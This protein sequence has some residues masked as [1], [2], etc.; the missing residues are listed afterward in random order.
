M[1]TDEKDST[2]NASA[3]AKPAEKSAVTVQPVAGDVDIRELI[4]QAVKEELRSSSSAGPSADST[5]ST[6]AG[7][8]AF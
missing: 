1:A 5:P 3:L 6:S 2:S 4:R 7:R 8:H